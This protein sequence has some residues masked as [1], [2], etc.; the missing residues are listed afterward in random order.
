MW[1][2]LLLQKTTSIQNKIVHIFFTKLQTRICV[3]SVVL[4]FTHWI[5]LWCWIMTDLFN[6][7]KMD[8][9]KWKQNLYVDAKSFFW[10]MW[11][12]ILIHI[13]IINNMFLFDINVNGTL[14]KL[15]INLK[16]HNLP[17]PI[18]TLS[19]KPDCQLFNEFNAI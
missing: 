19:Y 18:L 12:N 9:F 11:N 15:K 3:Q 10:W 2:M 13:F 16:L 4:K 6:R 7:W 17:F 8:A 5:V 14:L 1:V